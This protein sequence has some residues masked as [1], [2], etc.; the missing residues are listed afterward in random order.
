M[1]REGDA[2]RQ[3]HERHDPGN[4]IEAGGCGRGDYGGSVLLNEALQNEVVIVALIECGL[5]LI[6]HFVGGL[7]AHVIAFEQNLTA[8]AGAHHAMAQVF[9]ASARISRTHEGKH[10]ERKSA[11]L[12]PPANRVTGYWVLSTG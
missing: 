5:Q 4:P 8:S 12:Q 11:S 6:A 7:A 10:R 3:H 2:Q 9:E 1:N